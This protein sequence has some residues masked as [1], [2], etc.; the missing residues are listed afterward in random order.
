MIY[1]YIHL[2]IILVSFISRVL[3]YSIDPNMPRWTGLHAYIFYSDPHFL[4]YGNNRSNVISS[5]FLFF[6][7]P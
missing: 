4:L 5:F 3:L 1:I 6:F 2:Y 7:F